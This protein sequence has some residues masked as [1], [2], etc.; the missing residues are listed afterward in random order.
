MYRMG[1]GLNIKQFAFQFLDQTPQF[2]VVRE[3]SRQAVH[4]DL[5]AAVVD[6]ARGFG[7][8]AQAHAAAPSSQAQRDIPPPITLSNPKTL[9]APALLPFYRRHDSRKP[10]P[11]S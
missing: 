6:A 7:Q 2:L 5:C 4:G 9:P 10:G 11:L 1:S 3:S 8:L